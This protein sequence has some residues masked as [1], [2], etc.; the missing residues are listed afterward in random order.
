MPP[1]PTQAKAEQEA[2]RMEFVIQKETQEANRKKIEASPRSRV[3]RFHTS[4]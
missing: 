2:A 4:S 3:A 1:L